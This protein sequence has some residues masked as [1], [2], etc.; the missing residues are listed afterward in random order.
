MLS[1]KVLRF[2]MVPKFQ[3]CRFPGLQGC[4]FRNFQRSRI[5]DYQCSGFQV[6]SVESSKDQGST[7]T[8]SYKGL[9]NLIYHQ[10]NDKRTAK[11]MLKQKRA[12]SV[13]FKNTLWSIWSTNLNSAVHKVRGSMFFT[14]LSLSRKGSKGLRL[15]ETKF[16]APQFH[17]SRVSYFQ[18]SKF[19]ASK[20]PWTKGSPSW[21]SKIQRFR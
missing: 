13:D 1:G 17:D 8:R 6:S 12:A 9:G 20:I 16:G 3:S 14:K 5:L 18:H 2:C 11:Q 19:P 15:Q 4:K 7:L 10:R 21:K